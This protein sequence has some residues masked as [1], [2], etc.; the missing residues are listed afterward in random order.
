MDIFDLIT[1][2]I[3]KHEDED[4]FAMDCPFCGAA[5]GFEILKSVYSVSGRCS[6]CDIPVHIRLQN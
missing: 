5:Q 1:A 2:E 4:A 3:R 6:A